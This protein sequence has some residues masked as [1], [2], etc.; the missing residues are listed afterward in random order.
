MTPAEFDVHV[1]QKARYDMDLN[2]AIIALNE[3]AGEVAGWYKKAVL[4]KDNVKQLTDQ[5]LAEEVGDVI[6]YIFR[7]MQLKGWT[8]D[9][10]TDWNK[11]KLE[12]RKAMG[13]KQLL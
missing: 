1:S 7:I 10:I 3:E 13:Y 11:D 9:Q 2:Y 6:Y 8:F 12:A 4:R 5:D